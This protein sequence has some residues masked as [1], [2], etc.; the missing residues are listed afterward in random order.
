M[1]IFA[2]KLETNQDCSYDKIK[3][4]YRD[5]SDADNIGRHDCV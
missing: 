1:Y 3:D 5:C 2:D 4:I